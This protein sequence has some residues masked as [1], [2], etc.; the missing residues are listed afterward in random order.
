MPVGGARGVRWALEPWSTWANLQ[1]GASPAH[2]TLIIGA[3]KG[4]GLRQSRVLGCLQLGVGTRVLIGSSSSGLMR[5]RRV[6]I[7]Y[8]KASGSG[9]SGAPRLVED[10]GPPAATKAQMHLE[11]AKYVQKSS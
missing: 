2:A 5:H 9:L 7:S 4:G 3:K 10:R 1:A 11:A 6:T 8:S